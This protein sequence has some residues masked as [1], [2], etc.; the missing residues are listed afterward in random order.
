MKALEIRGLKSGFV[1]IASISV[2]I[3]MT[4]IATA[5]LSLSAISVRTSRSEWAQEEAR[6][7]A[8]L[9]LMIAIGELQRDLGPDRRIA[10]NAAIMDRDPD[11]LEI[12]GVEQPHWLAYVSSEYA[13]NASGS[14]LYQR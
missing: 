3:L 11:T 2:L 1:L 14:P 6:A 12:E 7:N 4:L 13:G 8:R 9:A 5:F 10:V